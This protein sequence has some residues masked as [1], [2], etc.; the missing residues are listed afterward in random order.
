MNQGDFIF[1]FGA[2]HAAL[3]HRTTLVSQSRHRLA[4]ARKDKTFP[5]TGRMMQFGGKI[6]SKRKLRFRFFNFFFGVSIFL[7]PCLSKTKLL[8]TTRLKI[9]PNY[10]I[11]LICHAGRL[12]NHN[13]SRLF[14]HLWCRLR[15]AIG[16]RAPAQLAIIRSTKLTLN[17]KQPFYIQKKK[18]RKK[19]CSSGAEK[20]RWIPKWEWG[21]RESE[22]K[23]KWT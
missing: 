15:H 8:P 13:W 4:S 22:T 23:H 17:L 3:F 11:R 2:C 21:E 12:P 5:S 20:E 18:E 19:T 14:F 10:V 7:S 6:L 16:N 9:T 1:F